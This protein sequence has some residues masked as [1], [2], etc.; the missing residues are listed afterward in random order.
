MDKNIFILGELNVDL[1]FTGDD[2]TPEWNK[3][4]LVDGF[5]QVLGSSSAITASCLAGLGF[6]VYFVGVVGDDPFGHFCKEQLQNNGVQTDYVTID[7]TLTTGVT[8]SLSTKE[9]RALLTYMGAI[10]KLSE[11]YLPEVLFTEADHIHFGSYYLQEGMR[12]KWKDVFVQ[13]KDHSISTSFDTGWDPENE[14]DRADVLE[15]LE[16]T[17]FFIPSE[18]EL[19]QILQVNSMDQIIDHL[20]KQRKR[21]AVKERG[22]GFYVN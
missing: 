4:K 3:E 17:D 19:F 1:I 9:D 22:R 18:K 21:V 6:N 15:L 12:G 10:P 20:P 13:A 5:D 7:E 14:W 2:V 16:A 11:K 8:L